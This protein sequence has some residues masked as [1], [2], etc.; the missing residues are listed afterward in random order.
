MTKPR[1]GEHFDGEEVNTL[2]HGHVRPN[3]V[4]PVH[5]LAALGSRVDTEPSQ[6]VA[7]GLIGDAMAEIL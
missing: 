5:L 1:P 4:C 2:Q 3:E 6:D 7:D